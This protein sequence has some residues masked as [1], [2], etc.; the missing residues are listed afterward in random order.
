MQQL[1]LGHF[2]ENKLLNWAYIDR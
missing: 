2:L 1:V